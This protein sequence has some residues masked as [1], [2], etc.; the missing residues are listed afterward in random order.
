MSQ[1]MHTGGAKLN[2]AFLIAVFCRHNIFLSASCEALYAE[3]VLCKCWHAVGTFALLVRDEPI[4][5][6]RQIIPIDVNGIFN[7]HCHTFK[8]PSLM[9]VTHFVSP[10]ETLW[11]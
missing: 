6:I 8:H 9:D 10:T 7:T 2:P 3:V 11:Y 4:Y 5:K 1:H